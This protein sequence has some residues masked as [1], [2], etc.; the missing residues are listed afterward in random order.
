MRLTAPLAAIVIVAI[1]CVTASWL[2]LV[3]TH[4]IPV[5]T[6]FALVSHLGAFVTGSVL[7]L[8]VRVR[9]SGVSVQFSADDTGSFHAAAPTPDNDPRRTRP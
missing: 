9:A 1:L 2:A 8:V 7:P 4:T 3:L 6:G 5:E